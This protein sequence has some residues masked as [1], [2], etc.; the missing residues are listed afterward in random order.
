M[1]EK[2]TATVTQSRKL[3]HVNIILNKETQYREKTTMLEYVELAGGGAS[4]AK[5]DVDLGT[6]IV[7]KEIDA[8]IFV[9]GMTGGHSDVFGI[10][11]NIAKAVAK[12]N[13]PM[14]VGSQRAMIEDKNLAYTYDVKKFAK[15]IILIGNI[16]ATSLHR[17]GNETIQEM[18]DEVN[19]DMLA[20]HTNPAQES[21]QPEGDVDFRGIFK[22]IVEVAKYVRQPTILKEVGNGVS[23]EVA[24][25]LDGKVYG[26]D[27]QGAGGTT[28]VG[29][30]TYRS[31]GE[32]G[33]AFW[34]W[35][36]PTAL[37]VL[38]TKDSFKGKVFASGGIRS[39]DDVIRAVALGADL[40]G[41]AKPVLMSESRQGSDGVYSM[42]SSIIEDMKKKMAKLG[43]RNIGELKNAKVL[44]KEPLSGVIKQR[45]VHVPG[46]FVLE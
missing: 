9:S 18:L 44:I 4:I 16:G 7:G 31:K 29:V 17:Y 42:L 45:G 23:K 28:W 5:V 6:E 40:C 36:I 25:R 24:Q 15:D 21:V 22:R 43:L 3:E 20:I 13:I 26:I 12:L 11:K 34:D 1:S 14:G 37:S 19:A 8:P 35:G 30:E 33:L 39:A 32:E 38:E 10:N 2:T 41:M 46:R 27:V